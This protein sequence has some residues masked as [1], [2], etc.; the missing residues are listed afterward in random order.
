MAITIDSSPYTISASYNPIKW[1]ISSS[2]GTIVRIIADVYID[3]TVQANIDKDPRFGTSNEF[4]F[5]IQSVCKD[6]LTEN[7]ESI[8][9]NSTVDAT[10]SEVKIKIDFYEVTL[11][12]GILV[13]AWEEDGTGTPDLTTSFFWV[14]NSAL[15]HEETQNL[16]VYSTD[17]AT[18][19]FLSHAPKTLKLKRTETAQ[20]HFLTFELSVTTRIASYNSS[21]VLIATTTSSLAVA[22]K[23]V[24]ALI[25]GSTFVASTS[26]IKVYIVDSIGTTIS[27]T[28]RYNIDEACNDNTLRLKWVNPL[29]GIDAYTFTSKLKEELRFRQKTF[30]RVIEKGYAIKERGDTVLSVSGSDALEVYSSYL[31]KTELEWLSQIGLSNNVWI[32]DGTFIPVIVTSRKTK[33][34]DTSKKVFQAAFKLK[35]ANDRITQK[36]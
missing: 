16:N 1:S 23:A 17:V 6:Y 15:Q 13:T 22:D 3:G 19:P 28:I 34:L 32:D 31:T 20:L 18:K 9:G 10:N 12:G 24:I 35:K 25:D 5:D 8:S 30:E 29:G 2:T 7:I 26:Y 36:G 11:V 21:D 14:T 27:E 4:D 33:T